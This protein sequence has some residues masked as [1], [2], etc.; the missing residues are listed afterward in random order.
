MRRVRLL[1][2]VQRFLLDGFEKIF[3]R[4][5]VREAGEFLQFLAR[6]GL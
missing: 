3:A 2:V 4:F 1:G 6:L 5:A